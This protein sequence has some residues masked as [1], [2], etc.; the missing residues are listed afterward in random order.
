MDIVAE[1]RNVARAAH[2]GQLYNGL[3]YEVH[4]AAVAA[5]LRDFRIE[6]SEFVAAA[7]LHDV[8]EDTAVT[9]EEVDAAFGSTVARLVWAVTGVGEDRATRNREIYRKIS[10]HPPAATLK[11]ADR[12]AN[13]EAD[14][15]GGRHRARYRRELD[16]FEAVVRPHV[17]PAMWSRLT[18]A[19]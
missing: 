19:L 11:L 4:L 14:V 9:R 5:V 10:E 13:V 16:D 15:P 18:A 1:A 2:A 17:E 12:I 8:I 3:P 6:S 7:W